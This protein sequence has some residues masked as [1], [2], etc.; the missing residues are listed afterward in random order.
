MHPPLPNAPE[1]SAMPSTQFAGTTLVPSS[2]PASTPASNDRTNSGE[3]NHFTGQGWQTLTQTQTQTSEQWQTQTGSLG[4]GQS[5]PPRP[6]SMFDFVP[7]YDPSAP[8]DEK[9]R[10]HPVQ[11]EYLTRPVQLMTSGTPMPRDQVRLDDNANASLVADDR[12]P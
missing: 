11:T 9:V 2:H 3:P 1:A 7:N 12:R 5:S 6:G 10:L 4:D 8:N